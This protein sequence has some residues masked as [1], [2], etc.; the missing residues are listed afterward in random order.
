[1]AAASVVPQTQLIL[2]SKQG[3]ERS[4]AIAQVSKIIRDWSW[5]LKIDSTDSF[6]GLFKAGSLPFR[7]NPFL[8][9]L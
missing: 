9:V 6:Q 5:R 7:L 4:I 2:F 3:N 1:M 8:E